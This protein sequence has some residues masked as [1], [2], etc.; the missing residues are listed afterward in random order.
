MTGLSIPWCCPS[1]VY[2]V[3]LCSLQYD[4][5]HS[6]VRS[7]CVIYQSLSCCICYQMLG[8]HIVLD[9]L[10]ILTGNYVIS[11]FWLTASHITVS[12]WGHVLVTISRLWFNQFQKSL[13]FWKGWLSPSFSVLRPIRHF[14]SLTSKMGLNWTYRRLYITH[15]YMA[16]SNILPNYWSWHCRHLSALFI[17]SVY[18]STRNDVI[19]CLW[20][21]ANANRVNVWWILR[22]VCAT[23]SR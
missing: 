18:I 15:S 4:F 11:Y 7:F 10:F 16:N 23:F 22:Y 2:A 20:S 8:E 12:I 6:I 1:T 3:F 17:D 19:S 9:N 5:W 21:T 13:Q 14:C